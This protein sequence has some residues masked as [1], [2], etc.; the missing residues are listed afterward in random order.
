MYLSIIFIQIVLLALYCYHIYYIGKEWLNG[1]S[2]ISKSKSQNKM[3]YCTTPNPQ[4]LSLNPFSFQNAH[5][6]KVCKLTQ[7]FIVYNIS[8]CVHNFFFHSFLEEEIENFIHWW[9]FDSSEEYT[10]SFLTKTKKQT[11]KADC[12]FS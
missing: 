7:T 12:S 11:K 8:D 9:Q 6:G 10:Y 2:P 5:F 1:S 3:I 4:I